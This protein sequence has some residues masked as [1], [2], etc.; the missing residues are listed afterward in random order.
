[1]PPRFLRSDGKLPRI[2]KT[3]HVFRQDNIA[4]TLL[5]IPYGIADFRALIKEGYF[6]QDRTAYLPVIENA[7][8]QLLFLRPRRFGK[9]LLLSMLENYY[10]LNQA[11]CFDELFGQLAIGR[12]PTPLHNRYFVMKWDFST[13]AAHSTI[14]DIEQSIHH[15]INLKVT[16]CAE[17]Y[18][19]KI[20]FDAEDALY[21]FGS[22]LSAINKTPY[23]LYLL[24]DEY[25]NFANE[26]M[27]AGTT[28]YQRL[29]QGEGLLKTV[30][31]NIKAAAAGAGLDRVFIT[32]VSPMVMSDMTSGYNVAI[33]IYLDKEFNTLCGFTEQEISDLLIRV[34]PDHN[35]HLAALQLMRTFY[36]GYRFAQE[37]ETSVYNPTLSLYFIRALQQHQHYPDNLLDENLAMDR[38]KLRYIAKLPYGEELIVAALDNQKNIYIDQ[39]SERF[40]VEDVLAAV[41]DQGFMASLL[42]YFG[43]LTQAGPDP[44]LGQLRLTIPNLVVRRLYL[45]R[46][47]DM[48]ITDYRQRLQQKH[49]VEACYLAADLQPLCEFIE[50][51]YFK[52]LSNRDYRW[53]NE[54][55]LKIIFMTLLYN[56]HL[57]MMV[58]ELETGRRYVDLSLIVRPD[59]RQYQALDLVLEFK[60]IKLSELNISAEQIHTLTAEQLKTLPLVA[61]RL[62]QALAQAKTYIAE[63]RSQYPQARLHGLAVVAIGFERVVFQ[64]LAT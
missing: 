49:A 10:D 63:L 42:Y 44:I 24:I 57:Y 28:H 1:M 23:R 43:I 38:N 29:L 58:S 55:M 59:K 22:L 8:K 62:Q 14:N 46:L 48:F 18:Q 50:Q 39:L 5:K 40:G 3:C 51:H 32:G 30:F 34:S 35:D 21:S 56:D 53:V 47:N 52:A 19:L 12:N 45:E 4:M 9:S 6:Y 26:V 60:L 37:T 13:I 17:R 7:G 33:N 61:E 20:H 64:S 16:E 11:E 2:V 41:K 27:I 54:L 15:H 31:K 25:D 36:N